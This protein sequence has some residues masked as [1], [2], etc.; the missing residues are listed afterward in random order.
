MALD[1]MALTRLNVNI[2]LVGEVKELMEAALLKG[3]TGGHKLWMFL[4]NFAVADILRY[5]KDS[6][7]FKAA[8]QG[9]IVLSTSSADSRYSFRLPW[10]YLRGLYPEFLSS[11]SGLNLTVAESV[12]NSTLTD[13]AAL[14]YDAVVAIALGTCLQYQDNVSTLSD[15]SFKRQLSGTIGS[16]VNFL[17][18][19]GRVAFDKYG[20]REP[21]DHAI[22]LK[23]YRFWTE[24]QDVRLNISCGG[25]YN[26]SGSRWHFFQTSY[27]TGNDSPPRYVDEVVPYNHYRQLWELVLVRFLAGAIFVSSGLLFFWLWACRSRSVVRATQPHLLAVMLCGIVIA[28]NTVFPLSRDEG[29]GYTTE[30][31]TQSC[32]QVIWLVSSGITLTSAAM[33]CKLYRV[34]RI[35]NAFKPMVVSVK[36]ML[37]LILLVLC[38]DLALVAGYELLSPSHWVRETVSTDEYGQVTES[39]G[40]CKPT[41][42]VMET[43]VDLVWAIVA[44]HCAIYAVAVYFCYLARGISSDFQDSQWVMTS[45]FSQLQLLL[46]GVPVY[47]AVQGEPVVTFVVQT[48]IILL[49]NVILLVC[50]FAPKVLRTHAGP[51]EVSL[52][53]TSKKTSIYPE[54]SIRN[55]IPSQDMHSSVFTTP[56][57]QKD[58]G[59]KRTGNGVAVLEPTKENRHEEGEH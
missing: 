10:V 36:R 59:N 48:L 42:V 11:I 41:S 18:L 28:T 21:S 33:L 16:R 29:Q 9:S 51:T 49:F 15:Q 20:S 3:L 32:N 1:A 35:F 27:P 55:S 34:I 4:E 13:A 39:V 44:F 38:F 12:V 14:A 50:M 47:F 40:S 23:S 37:A 46:L 58:A 6:P 17:G 52:S 5:T 7:T 19:S 26:V 22:Q 30:E 45:I 24:G 25:V 2:A 8:F 43:T 31:L 54:Q 53:R 57:Q 56:S